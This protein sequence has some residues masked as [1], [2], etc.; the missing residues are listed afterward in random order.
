MKQV[1]F[2]NVRI[3]VE[4]L[5]HNF[6][7]W[8]LNVNIEQMLAGDVQ[9]FI[10]TRLQIGCY[11]ILVGSTPDIRRLFPNHKHSF[12]STM[13]Y[14]ARFVGVFASLF[15]QVLKFFHSSTWPFLHQ[16]Q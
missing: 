4:Y 16:R 2:N 3:S 10:N 13:H 11:Y 15:Y 1:F 14:L 8:A 5:V 7:Y 12:D 9:G 6:L